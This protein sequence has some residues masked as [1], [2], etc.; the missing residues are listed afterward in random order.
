MRPVGRELLGAPFE[1]EVT[2]TDAIRLEVRLLTRDPLEGDSLFDGVDFI[3]LDGDG[4]GQ[5]A[6]EPEAEQ[7]SLVEAYN[8]LRRALLTHDHF[9]VR[10][11]PAGHQSP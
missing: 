5:L 3:A 11:V 6:I 4:D 9:D 10:A 7:Q 2:A 1:Y 8:K